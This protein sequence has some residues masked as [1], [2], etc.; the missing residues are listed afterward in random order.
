MQKGLI[1]SAAI[2]AIGS[3]FAKFLG[4]FLKVLLINIVGD[5]EIGLYQLPYPIYTTILTFSM[6]GFSLA[7]AKLISIYHTEKDY[8]NAE[9]AFHLSLILITI[10][11]FIFTLKMIEIF[12]WPQE[13]LLPYLALVP[14]LFVVSVQSAYRGYFNGIKKMYITSIS[15]II[16][17]IGRVGFGLGLCIT[18]L[19]RGIPLSIAGALLGASLVLWPR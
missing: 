1:Y 2:L 12:K 19:P 5:Y 8:K 13:A 18:F 7:V 15:Q 9:F 3:I 16:E 14:A 11:S 6:T 17:S 4:V 10:L